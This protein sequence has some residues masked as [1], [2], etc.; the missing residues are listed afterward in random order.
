V[1]FDIRAADGVAAIWL[2]ID[3]G[4]MQTTDGGKTLHFGPLI[5]AV[6]LLASTDSRHGPRSATLTVQRDLLSTETLF[7][8]VDGSFWCRHFTVRFTPDG[9]EVILWVFDAAGTRAPTWRGSASRRP[10]K[11]L[12][13]RG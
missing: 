3:A 10:L 4:P 13:L 9:G 8:D 11:V 6:V 5:D 7:A 1:H 12:R 2:R